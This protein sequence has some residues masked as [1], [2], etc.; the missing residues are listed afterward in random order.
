VPLAWYPLLL[1]ALKEQLRNW[2]DCW[3]GIRHP[4]AG[5]G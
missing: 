1:H 4:L 3:R 2:E 5:L